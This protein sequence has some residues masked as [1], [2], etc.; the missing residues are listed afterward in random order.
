MRP[1]DMSSISWRGAPQTGAGSSNTARDE[2]MDLDMVEESLMQLTILIPYTRDEDIPVRMRHHTSGGGGRF[3]RLL[4]KVA[5]V[6]VYYSE[7]HHD[8]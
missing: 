8:E 7:H 4:R 1:T 3:T 6:V 5:R 2:E